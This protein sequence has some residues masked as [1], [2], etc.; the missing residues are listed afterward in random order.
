MDF[1]KI[2]ENTYD[3]ISE[4]WESKRSYFWKPI[5]DFLI[6]FE[7]K[8]QL[9]LL[10][11]GCGTGRHLEA[12][13]KLG[14]KKENLTGS[15]ISKNQLEIV[16]K[17]GYKTQKAD[18]ID[19]NFFKDNSFDIIVCIAAHHHLIKK[20][21]QIQA[22]KEMNRILNKDGK[23]LLS[24]W[25]PDKE[26]IDKQLE[27]NKFEFLDENKQIVKVT[28]TKDENKFDRYYY[29]FKE[30]ELKEIIEQANLKIENSFN[31]KGNYYLILT[32]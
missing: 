23:I 7:N 29:L 18:L 20:E 11:L 25:F 8:S 31:N 3:S 9:K 17:K 10:D 26:F 13:E 28:F 16:K 15:D 2:N 32:K 19:L 12:A 5:T 14:F 6:S 27:K 21:E 24:N 4:E 30:D 22:L 1:K